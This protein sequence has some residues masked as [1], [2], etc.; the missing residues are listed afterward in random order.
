LF[1]QS[2]LFGEDS[3]WFI[4]AREQRI[5]IKRLEEVTLYVR[6]HGANMTEGKNLLELN[7]LQVFKKAL[8]RRRAARR[9]G[10]E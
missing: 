9:D 5:K 8:D 10:Q 3:D 1:D 4:R 2:L 6:R 7:T